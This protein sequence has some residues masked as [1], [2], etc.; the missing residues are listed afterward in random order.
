MTTAVSHRVQ[1]I[2]YTRFRSENAALSIL[3]LHIIDAHRENKKITREAVIV[4]D[5]RNKFKNLFRATS[6]RG[7][8]LR[9][10]WIMSFILQ[11]TLE[12]FAEIFQARASNVV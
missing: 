2:L 6:L 3:H 5:K 1:R 7:S 11:V 10:L 8:A 12:W 9:E 4:K